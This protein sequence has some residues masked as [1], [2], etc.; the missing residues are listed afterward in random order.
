MDSLHPMDAVWLL[1]ATI[2]F[3]S[4]VEE[5]AASVMLYCLLFL[6]FPMIDLPQILEDEYGG[7]LSPQIMYVFCFHA[8]HVSSSFLKN[9]MCKCDIIHCSVCYG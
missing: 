4:Q 1:L 8:F 6:P 3:G 7:W 9:M 2:S 5:S